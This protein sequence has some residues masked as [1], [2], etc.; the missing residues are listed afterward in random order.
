MARG[1]YAI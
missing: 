1:Q